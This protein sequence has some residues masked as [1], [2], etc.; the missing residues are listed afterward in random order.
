MALWIG[1]IVGTFVVGLLIWEFGPE[2]RISFNE[3]RRREAAPVG[4]TFSADTG[5]IGVCGGG[6]DAGGCGGDGG[7]GGSC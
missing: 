1:L 7:G 3:F 6:F 2:R 4:G 5:A